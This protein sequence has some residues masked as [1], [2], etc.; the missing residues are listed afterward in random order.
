MSA[1]SIYGYQGSQSEFFKI[2]VYNAGN[3]KK[4]AELSLDGVD[5][6]SFQ[7]YEMHIDTFQHF[8]AEFG[9]TGM[10][11]LTVNNPVFRQGSVLQDVKKSNYSKNTRLDNECDCIYSDI[12][13]KSIKIGDEFGSITL[14]PVYKLWTVLNI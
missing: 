3:I 9:V 7:P 4:L 14:L 2:E 12:L 11:W 5:G 1:F 6:F 13:K 8:Y 10:D